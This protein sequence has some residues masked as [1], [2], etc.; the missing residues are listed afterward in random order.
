VRIP[1]P[2]CHRKGRVPKIFDGPMSYYNPHTGES[3]PHE[4]CQ[5]C[6]GS[7][8]V[9]DSNPAKTDD[10]SA[11]NTAPRWIDVTHWMSLP[12]PPTSKPGADDGS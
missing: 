12:A 8:W 2:T 1:C 4:T 10:G 11:S 9:N 3:W 7:G 5:T 6:M